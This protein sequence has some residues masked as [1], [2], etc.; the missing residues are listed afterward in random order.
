ML[1]VCFQCGMYRADKIIDPAGPYAICPEC[2]Y[3][4]SFVYLPLLVISGASGAGKSTICNQL[5]GQV[6]KAVLLDSDILWRAEFSSPEN[7]FR[8]YFE[9]WLRVCKN[10]AQSGRPV[11]LFG[12]GVGVPENLEGCIE[13]RYFSAI[14]YLALV[15]S[16]E[17]LTER[18]RNRPAWRGSREQTYIE[19]HKRFNY[20][21]KNYNAVNQPSIK[22]IDT[23]QYSLQESARQVQDWIEEKAVFR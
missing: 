13:R 9:T 16:D 12:A 21:F 19:E 22:L 3:Q 4:H 10:I 14:H 23:S 8:D 7:N 2:G 11:V 18:L 15:C 1:N 17:A 6:K 5:V 20:W